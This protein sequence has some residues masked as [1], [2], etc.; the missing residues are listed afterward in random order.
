MPREGAWLLLG[1]EIAPSYDALPYRHGSSPQDGRSSLELARGA[2]LAG[3]GAAPLG[4]KIMEP[5][6]GVVY[7]LGW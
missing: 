1:R 7:R 3:P 2:I 6:A 5:C 4:R